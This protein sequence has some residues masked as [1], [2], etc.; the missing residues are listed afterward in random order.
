M[1][2]SNKGAKFY[3]GVDGSADAKPENSDLNL[4][5]YEGL[6]YLEVKN[7]GS[8][9][10]S[11]SNTNILTYDELD[12]TVIQ[13]SL[14][15]TNAGDPEVEVAISLTDPGQAEMR[16]AAALSSS[17]GDNF[18]FKVLYPSGRRLYNRGLVTGPRTPNG[19]NEDFQLETF[20][21]A[22]NQEQITSSS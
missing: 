11:G 19:R 10:E 6:T 12:T 18:A 8:V 14:G 9:G 22:L 3:I 16:A 4:A 5:A 2:S 15:T 20:A 7:V 13:K 1:A 21:L 17:N